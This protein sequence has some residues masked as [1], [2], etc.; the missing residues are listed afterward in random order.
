MRRAL[1][2]QGLVFGFGTLQR[3]FKR[4]AITRKKRP[5]TRAS[6]LVLTS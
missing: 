4:H 2:D 6:R 5:L 1:A 3:F